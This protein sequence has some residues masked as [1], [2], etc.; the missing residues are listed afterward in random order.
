MFALTYLINNI[1]EGS[2][3]HS[4]FTTYRLNLNT[5]QLYKDMDFNAANKETVIIKIIN[6]AHD[7]G[8]PLCP[9]QKGVYFE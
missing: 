3:S 6:R 1:E 2:S 7:I 5:G 9:L 4:S 8:I